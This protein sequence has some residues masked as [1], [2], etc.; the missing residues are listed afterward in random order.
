MSELSQVDP[1]IYFMKSVMFTER[2]EESANDEQ[3]AAGEAALRDTLYAARD[4]GRIPGLV[5]V[6]VYPLKDY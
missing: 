2:D 3:Y 5:E 1:S 6:R 4:H